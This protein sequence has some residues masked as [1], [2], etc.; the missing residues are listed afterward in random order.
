MFIVL[1]Q[2]WLCWYTTRQSGK[3][4]PKIAV[5]TDQQQHKKHKSSV[6][7]GWCKQFT[8][9]QFSVLSFKFAINLNPAFQSYYTTKTPLNFQCKKRKNKY[10][11][12]AK[13]WLSIQLISY[14]FLE[15]NECE[16]SPCK[17]RAACRDMVGGYRCYCLAGYTGNNCDTSN[18]EYCKLSMRRT[19]SG[20]AMTVRLKEVTDF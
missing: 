7:L 15:V 4:V 13:R 17:N 9:S 5:N 10:N 8:V 6:M 2:S 1:V 14:E 20:P 19:P 16:S 12:A 3:P 11:V 18:F